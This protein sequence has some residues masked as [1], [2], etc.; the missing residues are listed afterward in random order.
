MYRTSLLLALLLTLASCA[1]NGDGTRW[2]RGNLHTHSLWSDGNDFPELICDWY[3]DHDYDFLAISDHNIL[4]EG[5]KWVKIGELRKRGSITALNLY[6][7][8]YRKIAQTRGNRE[9]GTFEVRLTNFKDYKAMGERPGKFLIIQSEEISDQFKIPAPATR[10]TNRATTRPTTRRASTTLPIHMIATNIQEVIKPQGGNSV[11]EVLANNFKAIMEQARRTGQPILPHINHPN[12]GYA[13]TAA[14][15]ASVVDE[16]FFE[17]YNGHPG[18]NQLG[19]A[20]HIPIEHMWDVANTIRMVQLHAPPLMGLATD[21]T[22]H[23]HEPVLSRSRSTAGR[24]WVMV[25]AKDLTPESLIAA[26]QSGDF[27]ASSGVFL[28]SVQFNPATRT[29]SIKIKPDGDATFMTQFIGTPKDIAEG[30]KLDLTSEK[31]GTIFSTV[32]GRNPTYTLTGNELYVRA[33]ITSSKPPVNPSLKDQK[34]QAWTQPVV[35]DSQ[36]RLAR[37]E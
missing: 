30:G 17:V 34:K 16:H 25:R 18:V 12:F 35:L 36:P 4:A 1:N 10:P 14:D 21:D 26:I 37:S 7:D 8:Q 32:S 9:D 28:D 6:L 22:H 5:D 3:R 15:I 29:L 27:Y 31:I 19:D 23:Y 2:Y 33:L 24:G 13:L 20:R 11:A